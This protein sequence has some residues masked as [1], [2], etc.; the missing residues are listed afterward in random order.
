MLV[1][2]KENKR[3]IPEPLNGT[4]A[5]I[6]G[7][8]YAYEKGETMLQFIR[9]HLGSQLVPTLCDAPNLDPFGSCRVCSI[10]VATNAS[11]PRKVVASCHTP[12]APGMHL[13]PSSQKVQRLRKNILE[14][15]LTDHPLDCLTCEVNG[16]CELQHVAA[17][18]G[19]REVRYPAG[20]QHTD[21]PKDLSHP[22]M[23]SDLSKCINCY[24]CVR[25]C[26]EVQGQF[27]LTMAGRGFDAHIVKGADKQFL[28]SDCVS[29]GACAQACPTSAISDVFQ[30]K[31]ILATSKTRTVCTYCGVGCNLEVATRGDHEI[32][33]IRAPY[34][35]E[36]NHGHTCLKGRYAFQFYNHPERLRHPLIKRNGQFEEVTWEEAYHFITERLQ[37][38]LSDY[39]ADAIAGISSSRCTNEENYLMQ[40]FIRA[41]VGTNNIDGCARVCH[42]PT[43]LGMQRTFGTGAATNSVE[44]LN[45]TNCIL[46]IGA[47]PTD[48]HPV[49]G[50]RMKQKT[51]QGV[52]TIVIDP[53]E[54]ELAK[55]AHYHLQLRPGTNVAVLNM[56]MY[57]IVKE[58]LVDQQFIDQRTEGFQ[59][60]ADAL[61]NLDMD[62]MEA[63]S[64]VPRALVREAAIAYA[65][66]PNA[67]SFHG[68]GVTE[69]SQGTFTVMQIAEL[70]MLT[71]NIGRPGVGVNPLRGQNN[72]QGS[73]DMGVQP[74][75]GAGYLDI[76]R[77]DV[78]NRYESYY[79]VELPRH[80]GYKI[81]EMFDAALQ[82]KLKAIWIIGEDVV[83]T[84]P[85][86]Q[87]VIRALESID[88]VVVQE[89]FMT[90]TAKYADVVLPAS[91]FLEKSGT[92]TNGERRVQR[93]IQVIDPLPGTKPDGQII[94]EVMQRMGYPQPDYSA[95]AVLEE[96]A[97][98][99]PFFAGIRWEEL[100]TNGKQWP[101]SPDGVDSKIIHVE[102]FKRGKGRFEFHG[103]EESRERS[104]FEKD[105]PYI[106]TTNRELEHYNC[107]AMTRRTK[108]VEILTEDFLL[109]HP[110]DAV[111]HGIDTGD[112]VCVESPRGKVDIKAKLTHEVNPGVLS[113]TFHFPEIMVNN[114]TSDV[115]DSEAKCP[116]YKVVSVRIRKSKGK[117]RQ[118]VPV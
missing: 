59:S 64:G 26:D 96:I 107:G 39:G 42:S 112:M 51:M 35:A 89:L 113:T 49:T 90:E 100:G 117:Y 12:L 8:P 97:G 61:L 86:T 87:K 109:I 85:N 6:D 38:Y 116:E 102:S 56:M 10:E 84:D 15:V 43:A 45:H 60:F 23:V 53:R 30:S 17:Q 57:F 81:P 111:I 27:V 91:S 98:I 50:A 83:Q 108:N 76:T 63:V 55:Y 25:A 46:V 92:F 29:C 22:Y 72:V 115:H 73:A 36:V 80:V 37:A 65:S 5:Y 52:T 54:T 4:M 21:R 103:F 14:L 71:G 68:L 7:K 44:D 99:V 104:E 94:A 2:P 1:T 75:Q 58:G 106:L 88:L 11:G 110:E 118:T 95:P 41:V 9:R 19:I 66:A 20:A 62:A 47:N 69:H 74:H 34:D 101:V 13:F 24:R 105:Y 32:L 78:R 79:G 67:M 82:G 93:V 3:P 18:V 48:A 70:A 114:I 77:E 16:N 33:S 31:A 28:E 40:K